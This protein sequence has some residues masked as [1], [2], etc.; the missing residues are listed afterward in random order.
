MN[1]LSDR[2]LA[3]IGELRAAG[4]RISV[5][6]SID[7]MNAVV[8]SGLERVPMREALAVSLIKDEADREA[9][10]GAFVQFF[11]RPARERGMHPDQRGQAESAASGRRLHGET[12]IAV[13]PARPRPE[14]GRP[15]KKA[16]DAGKKSA[17]EQSGDETKDEGEESAGRRDA[18]ERKDEQ[19]EQN[20]AEA[21]P[22]IEAARAARLRALERT[23][24]E[25][26][27]DLEYDEAR[28]A[29][30]PLVRRFRIRLGRRLRA[31]KSGRID[32][33]RTIRAATQRGGVLIDLRH[34]ARRPRHLDLVILADISG[35]VRYA[36]GLMLEL[37]AGAS[38]CFRRVSAF[39]YVDH[40]AEASFEQGHLVTSPPLDLYARSDFGRVLAELWE[41]RTGLLTRS[42]LVVI[43]GDGR[44]NR[45]PARADLLREIARLSRGVVWLNPE[46]VSRWST[47]DSAIEQYARFAD[48]LL[49]ARNLHELQ[50]AMLR[51]A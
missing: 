19:G 43:M 12:P 2:L 14:A 16:S 31:A 18:S 8:A 7:A 29:L 38:G 50:A 23:P 13:R 21:G 46:E 22:G 30:A 37:V 17:A 47:G 11:G 48:A 9:F 28:E 15:L 25:R 1:P 51:V 5:A 40:L 35:S 10:D 27:S 6:E 36:A 49:P 34:R 45:R 3:F 20:F 44:N 39:A 33:R 32:F 41:R 24:F 26:Y 4:I 42:T